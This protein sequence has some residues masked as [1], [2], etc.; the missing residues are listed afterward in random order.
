M[1]ILY[2]DFDRAKKGFVGAERLQ[3]VV[4][5]VNDWIADNPVNVINVETVIDISGWDART[6]GTSAAVIRVWY[7]QNR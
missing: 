2:K 1:K 4:D 3:D 6:A 7:T 5:R